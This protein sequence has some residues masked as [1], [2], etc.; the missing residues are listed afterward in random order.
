MFFKYKDKNKKTLIKLKLKDK[1]IK[2]TMK[3]IQY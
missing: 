3:N 2:L 1:N